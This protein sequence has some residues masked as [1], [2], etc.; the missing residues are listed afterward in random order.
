[1]FFLVSVLTQQFFPTHRPPTVFEVI[2]ELFHSSDFN[3]IAP[4][5][6][7]HFDF[8]AA[9]PCTYDLVAGLTPATP[10]KIE[11]SLTSMRSEVLR[12]ISR[13][14]Q[15]G[16]GEGG[17]DQD[18]EEE[19]VPDHVNVGGP[20]EGHT[21]YEQENDDDE[22]HAASSLANSTPRQPPSSSP[23]SQNGSFGVLSGRPVQALQSR[24][25][26]LNGKPSYLL[27]FWEVV[28]AHQLLQ[29]S[30]QRLSN[31]V[32]AADGASSRSATT[33][34]S[35]GGS[36]IQR[37]RRD[38]QQESDLQISEASMYVPLAKS[39]KDLADS[40]VQLALQRKEDRNHEERMEDRR[41]QSETTAEHRKRTFQRRAELLDQARQYR[42]L[43]AELNPNDDNSQ[44]LS[45]F[46]L[47]ECRILQQEIDEIVD[48]SNSGS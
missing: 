32:G 39:L 41:Q 44:R 22:S 14:E 8:Q 43:N 24:S 48:N 9:T 23:S 25:A 19:E 4:S 3:P 17:R 31:N 45:H 2:A 26:F 1:M 13:W 11:D 30:L 36:S 27:Y 35:A 10:Q 47:E 38:Q 46:Y 7:C 15:S 42:R 37:R 29:S 33:S 6:D 28:D 34:D 12:I 5:S 18:E 16:Q 21:N 40:H 20:G